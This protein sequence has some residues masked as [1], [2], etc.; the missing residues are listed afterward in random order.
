MKPLAEKSSV[1]SIK[2][3]DRKEKNVQRCPRNN[4]TQ[5][6]QCQ[7]SNWKGIEMDNQ[8]IKD[9]ANQKLPSDRKRS[10]ITFEL[11]GNQ[12]AQRSAGKIPPQT[13]CMPKENWSNI[14]WT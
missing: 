9:L 11:C 3:V 10:M 7:S 14:S 2:K 4:I 13:H 8:N 5:L 6:K 1:L 12:K